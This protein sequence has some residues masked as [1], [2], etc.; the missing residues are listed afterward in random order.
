MK[1]M[2]YKLNNHDI[3]QLRIITDWSVFKLWHV[4]VSQI[5]T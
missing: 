4:D 1:V 5:N 3:M 2:A